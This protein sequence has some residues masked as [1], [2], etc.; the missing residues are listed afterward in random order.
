MSPFI[1]AED[2]HSSDNLKWKAYQSQNDKGST[3]T[4]PVSVKPATPPATLQ[5]HI[6]S[7]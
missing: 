5:K 1:L 2:G 3:R 7:G 6:I 4:A